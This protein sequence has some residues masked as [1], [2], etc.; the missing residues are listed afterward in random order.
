MKK[1]V[2]SLLVGASSFAA[3]AGGFQVVLQGVRQTS[4]GNVAT[5]VPDA[6]SIF[7]NPGAV[8]MLEGNVVSAGVSPIISRISYLE[9]EPYYAEAK[10][11]NPVSLPFYLYAAFGFG[12]ENE[13]G[14]KRLK[15]GIGVFTPYGSTVKWED[16]WP[17]QTYLRELSLRAI[18]IQPTVSFMINDYIGIGAG[19]DVVL[20]SINLKR[21]IADPT[22]GNFAEVDF[23]GTAETALGYNV[24]LF[25][26]SPDGFSFGVNYRSKVMSEVKE[27]DVTFDLTGTSQTFQQSAQLQNTKFSSSLPLP[28]VLTVGF[29]YSN[30]KLTVAT[31]LRYTQWSAYEQLKFEF[32]DPVGGATE[33]VSKRKYKDAI[34]VGIG[35][36]YGVTD[37]L[38][39]RV[40]AYYDFTPVPEGYMTAETPDANALGLTAGLGYSL[41]NLNI[42]AGFLFVNKEKRSQLAAT[43]ANTISGTFKTQAYIPSFGVSYNF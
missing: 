23:T 11:D 10:T 26:K 28:G 1:L 36:E 27:G 20:G 3:Y 14:V 33:S 31:D 24:G 2:L 13:N 9:N 35:A 17:K 22:T 18:Y 43:D 34:T 42:N 4:M 38:K 16:G 15:A 21:G 8:A 6:A 5:A 37:A 40:G 39:A 7:F 12:P 30:D 32:Q 19:L 29:A 25:V 41:G